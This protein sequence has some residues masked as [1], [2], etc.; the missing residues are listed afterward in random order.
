DESRY[1][2]QDYYSQVPGLSLTPNEFSGAPT[3]AIRGITSGDFTNP[4]VGITVDDV[5]FGPSTVNGGG[6]FAPDLDPS[7]LSRIEVLRGPQ[8]T[9]YGASSMGGLL[10]YVTA[11]P[12][13]Y[14][15]GGRVQAGLSHIQDGSGVGYNVSAAVNIPLSDT[16]AVRASAFTR[17]EP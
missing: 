3:I 11:D 2:L 4:T 6:Y 13:T 14:A 1:S 16:L 9:L 5:P 10:K 7:D 15:F 17:E 12:S 8:G